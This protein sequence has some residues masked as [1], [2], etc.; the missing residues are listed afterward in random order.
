MTITTA[1]ALASFEDTPSVGSVLRSPGVLVREMLAGLV[2]ALALI[3]EV[4]SFSFISGVDPRWRWFHP[5]CWA[6]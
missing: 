5:L 1:P 2:T 6:S 3:P 4:I